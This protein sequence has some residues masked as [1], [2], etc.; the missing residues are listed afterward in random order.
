MQ[1]YPPSNNR[2]TPSIQM[3]RAILL[4]TPG[5]HDQYYRPYIGN[6]DSIL[7]A[8]AMDAT[9]DGNRINHRVLSGIAGSIIQPSMM[10]DG[11]VI[12]PNGL[13]EGRFAFFIEVETTSIYG[14]EKE[15]I[16]GYTDYV[17]IS[18]H[19]RAIDPNMRFYINSRS[20]IKESKQATDAYKYMMHQDQ[21]AFQPTAYTGAVTLRPE[22]AV[23]FAQQNNIATTE[24]DIMMDIRHL[25]DGNTKVGMSLHSIPSH[26]LADTINGYINGA[27]QNPA[28]GNDR[29][30]GGDAYSVTMESVRAAHL[31]TSGFYSAFT[32]S[33]SPDSSVTYNEIKQAFNRPDSFWIVIMPEPGKTITSPR[34]YTEHWRGATQE[35]VIV[36]SLSHMLPALMA[37]VLL[38]KLNVSMTNMY[39]GGKPVIAILDVVPM[40]NN[41]FTKTSAQYLINQ[42][43]ILLVHGLILGRCNVF[44]IQIEADLMLTSTYNISLD[45]GVKYP[46]EAP[47]YCNT[48]YSPMIGSTVE[49]LRGVSQSVEFLAAN[50]SMHSANPWTPSHKIAPELYPHETYRLPDATWV[51]TQQAQMGGNIIP[52]PPKHNLY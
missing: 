43:E 45:G 16:R 47:M 13:S 46:Y 15:I 1:Q 6:V 25:T 36:Y 18:P 27:I 39:P 26:Y 23:S 29:S 51:D 44:D 30:D 41:A 34:A 21:I 19:T 37:E 3:V 9:D 17:G 11:K 38:M 50:L 5:Q 14:T 24:N 22:D 2:V 28:N 8:Q 20:I 33:I 48:A 42:I 12:I 32:R 10:T 35:T 40:F 49:Q 52:P 7:L 31:T 4:Y